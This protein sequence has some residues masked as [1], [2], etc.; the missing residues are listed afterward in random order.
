MGMLMAI[1]LTGGLPAEREYFL[2]ERPGPEVRDAAN[3]WL[4]EANGD[5]AM[6]IGVE[7]VAEQWDAHLYWLDIAFPD[8][9]VIHGRDYGKPHHSIGPEGKPTVLGAG[10]VAFRCVEPFAKWL[11]TFATES[12]RELTAEQLIAQE[13]PESPP[14]RQVSFEIEFVPAVPPLISG[15]LTES[16]RAAME[17]EQGSFLSPRHEQLC[18]ASGWLE[19]DGDRREFKAQVLRV[20]R[21]GRPQVRRVL[22]AQLAIRAVS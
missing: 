3:I 15:T 9:R 17:G 16:S 7:A 4:E 21:Q 14:M 2:A 13:F 18:R 1:D 10:P 8:G 6:R 19:I 20:K 12:V 5:F 22:G 11:V